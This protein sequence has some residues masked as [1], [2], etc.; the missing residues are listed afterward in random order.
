M[1]IL[2]ELESKEIWV[3]ITRIIF[4]IYLHIRKN[5]NLE[6]INSLIVASMSFFITWICYLEINLLEINSYIKVRR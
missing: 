4:S 6:Y 2:L 1:G 5:K 3:F